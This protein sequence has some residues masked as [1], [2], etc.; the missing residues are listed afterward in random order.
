MIG[1][2]RLSNYFALLTPMYMFD[3]YHCKDKDDDILFKFETLFFR[4]ILTDFCK[5]NGRNVFKCKFIKNLLRFV[6][7]IMFQS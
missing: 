5:V 7:K 1:L 2:D 4:Q 6:K 3:A